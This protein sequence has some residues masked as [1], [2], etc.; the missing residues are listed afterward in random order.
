MRNVTAREKLHQVI[1]DLSEQDCGPFGDFLLA[2]KEG[3]S[4]D[5]AHAAAQLPEST[6]VSAN[7]TLQRLNEEG[8]RAS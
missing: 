1:D 7:R 8:P 3:N 5:I 2:V 4:V 6:L